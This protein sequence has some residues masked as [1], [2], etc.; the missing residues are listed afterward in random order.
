ML[1]YYFFITLLGQ[2]FIPA[3]I[4]LPPEQEEKVVVEKSLYINPVIY[5]PVNKIHSM[6]TTKTISL[7]TKEDKTVQVFTVKK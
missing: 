2:N 6:S 4:C 3:D 7:E 1:N 5:L